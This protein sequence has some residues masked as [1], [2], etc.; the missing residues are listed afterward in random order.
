MLTDLLALERPLVA[1]DAETT[2]NDPK[3]DRIVQLGLYKLYPDGRLTEW[4]TLVNPGVPIPPETS[5]VHGVT[6]IAVAVCKK[7]GRSNASH[8]YKEKEACEAFERWPTFKDL[9]PML[10]HGLTDVDLLGYNHA[11]FDVPLLRAEFA[12]VNVA[13]EP[14]LFVD[15]F[16]IYQRMFPRNLA[17]AVGEYLHEKL[18]GA[19]DALIDARAVLRVVEAQL[20]RHPELPRSVRAL[21]DM[22]FVQ[23][24]RPD[25]LDPDG[26]IVWRNG[27]ACIG[28]GKKHGGKT[29]REVKALDPGFLRW[30]LKREFNDVVKKI[31]ADALEGRFPIKVPQ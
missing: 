20:L 2:G 3:V 27:E 15:G 10:A 14:G 4:S 25:T 22:F 18:E 26:K 21:N 7:C 28:F 19:H 9:A 5:G 12:R 16:R 31:A 23:P 6:D 30:I 13:W 8:E 17:A 1:I 11:H 29:L 24:S